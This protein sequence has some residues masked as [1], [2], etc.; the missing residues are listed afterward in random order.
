VLSAFFL[1]PGEKWS[2][3]GLAQRLGLNYSAVWKELVHLERLGIL[4]HE[5]RGNSKEYQV[6]PGCSIVPE[7]RSIVLKIE[8][9][10]LIVK[11]KLPDI[12]N[13]KE[14]FIYGSYASGE[15]DTSSDLDLMIIGEINLAQLALI[16]S[17]IEKELNRPINY[18]IFSEDEWNEKAVAKD[19]FWENV[20]RAPK[21]MLIGENYAL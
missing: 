19:P 1:A 8:G 7:L 10:G 15:A 21:I 13:V 18:I 3:W 16:I 6:N 14:A 11:E 20:V 12:G 9:I 5:Q 17:E 2:A 4:T